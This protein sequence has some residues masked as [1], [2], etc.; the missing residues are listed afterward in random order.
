M[1]IWALHFPL[2]SPPRQTLRFST[3][4]YKLRQQLELGAAA[5]NLVRMRR[6]SPAK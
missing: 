5:Y 2:N 3:D 1:N 4:L 6:L